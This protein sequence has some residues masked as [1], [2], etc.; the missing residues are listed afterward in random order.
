[1]ERSKEKMGQKRRRRRVLR[2]L[3]LPLDGWG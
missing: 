2:L 3:L 1:M